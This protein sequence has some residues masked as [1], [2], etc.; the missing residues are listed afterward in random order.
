VAFYDA[1]GTADRLSELQLR[2]SAGAGLRFMAPEFD[3]VVLRLDW[4]FPLS[5]GYSTLPGA[6]FFTFAQAFPIPALSAPSVVL[7]AQ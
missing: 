3:R 2:H 1:G 7:D 5:P 4:G 6:L